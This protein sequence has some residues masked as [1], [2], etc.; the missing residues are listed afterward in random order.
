MGLTSISFAAAHFLE[1]LKDQIGEGSFNKLVAR[2]GAKTLVFAIDTTGSMKDDIIAAKAI[3]KAILAEERAE[4]VD[5]I[6]SPF[7]D[8]GR[9]G[10]FFFLFII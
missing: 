3:T 5:F 1:T 2:N 8:P 9:V 10:H 4:R 6:L 7:N